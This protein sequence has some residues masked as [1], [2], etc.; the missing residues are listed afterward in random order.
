MGNSNF[1][2]KKY[3]KHY[4]IELFYRQTQ[5]LKGKDK[6]TAFSAKNQQFSAVVGGI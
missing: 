3:N 4:K 6:R 5:I 1:I 2:I